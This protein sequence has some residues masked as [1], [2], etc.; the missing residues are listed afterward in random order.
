LNIPQ[1][2]QGN[3]SF[4]LDTGSDLNMIKL[5]QLLDEV[6]V[7][8]TQ[9]Y[10]LKGINEYLVY[11]IGLVTL[12]ILFGEQRIPTQFQVVRDDFPVPNA[13]IIGKPFLVNNSLTI[14]YQTSKV[15][16]SNPEII[17]LAARTETL[18]PII[19]NKPEGT[20]LLVHSQ[21]TSNEA[22]QLGNALNNVIQGQ[23][24]VVAINSTE[25]PINFII[26]KLEELSFEKFEEVNIYSVQ[27]KSETLN[28]GNRI[29]ILNKVLETEH[30]NQ[31]ERESLIHICEQYSDIFHLEGDK[32]TCTDTV[33]HEINTDTSIQPINERPYRLPFKH[34]QEID[35]QITKLEED[36]IVTPSKSPWNAPLLVVPKKPDQDG[37]IKYRVCVDFRKLNNISTGDAY[38]L[39]NINDILDQLGKS[40]YYTTLDLAQGY[41]QIQ[42][43]PEHREKTAFSTDK[44]HFEFLRVPFGLKGAPATFQRMMNSVLTGLTGLK[45]FVYL[46]DII[47]YAHNIQ[48]HAEK[49]QAV[50]NRLR[51][52]NLKLQ[53]SKCAFMRKEVNY[54]GHIITEKG[55]KPDPKKTKC[56]LN[57]PIPVN[58]KDVKSFLG[59]S[60]YYRRFIPNYGCIAK[61]LTTLL[62]K[63]T[64]FQWSDLCQKAFDELK[65]ILT[66]EPLLQYP[67]FN[68]PFNLTCDASNYAIGCVLS[69]GT[70]G[71]DPPIAYASRTLNRAEQNYSTT[72][73]EL[74]A[75][76]WGVKQ[77]RPYLL[78]QK[79]NII[80]DHRALSWLF[81]IKDPG[82]RLTRWRLKLEEYEYEIHYKPGSKNTNADALSR[83]NDV[84]TIQTRS[85][86]I[87]PLESIKSFDE[88]MADQINKHC[89]NTDVKEVTGNIFDAPENFNLA[90]CVSADLKLNKGLALEFR[91]KYGHIRELKL[92]NPSKT[93]IL[94]LQV[95]SRYILNLVTKEKF[96]QKPTYE[97]IYKTLI[98]LKQFCR[99]HKL[100][101]IALPRIAC[102]LDQLE[103]PTVLNM[104]RYIYQNSGI[105]IQV[106]ANQD[107][108]I[109]DKQ[110]IIKEHHSSILGGHRGVR[111]T[112]KRIQRQYN[113]KT[114]KQDVTEYI[115]KCVSCQSNKTS[116]R[117][118]KQ[119]M[120]I[121]T[122]ATEPFEKIFIDVVGPLPR[123]NNDNAYILTMQC[124]LTKFSIAVPMVNH[125]ANTVAYHFVTSFVCLHGIP[126]T[127]VSDQGTEFL[128]R[129]LIE[130]CKLLKIKKCNTSPYHPQANGAL[131]RSHR[132]L[133][134]YLRH[135][136][137]ADQ[138]NWDTYIPYAMFVYNSS[139]HQATGKQPYELLYGKTLQ[140]PTSCTKAPEPRYNYDDYQAELRQKLQESHQMARDRLIQKKIRTKNIYDRTA[141]PIVVHVGDKVLIQD[142]ARKGKLSAKWLGPYEVLEVNSQEN[143]T[144]RKGNRK[145]KIH[146]NLL[147]L[148][149]D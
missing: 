115:S 66:K 79:F 27:N 104:I 121:S 32:L 103:W 132:T 45:A 57:F 140:V 110:Q 123:T 107:R 16:Q 131:E 139:E 116:N 26:P 71:K 1:C 12:D 125:E 83:I 74:C 120:V 30:L 51:Q 5:S 44:G 2:S 6:L 72:E 62:K 70:I 18:V 58:T 106:Y 114:L 35:K 75:I 89:P 46:D 91:R 119:P 76:V 20:T 129:I 13:G 41:H 97:D 86:R 82:S 80:T 15:F 93:K 24:I 142:K 61:P 141:N 87:E 92:Q 38:P 4:L 117:N 23:V 63:D 112:I 102:G 50:F 52:F 88:Y 28:K 25:S 124:D 101:N 53:P 96:W 9:I 118:T 10:Q 7:D 55:V 17:Q 69:Q 95:G 34:K 94:Y 36:N 130:T 134:E 81:N 21:S 144:I 22:V 37:V 148:F 64:K 113:W 3:A 108:D 49:L 145:T 85:K 136:V 133:G 14:D 135:Y 73:K 47:I 149:H 42:M 143:V 99:E 19:T 77:F 54:L 100:Q 60:G 43:H 33:Y 105:Q 39:P 31:E 56:V 126:N 147:K 68:Q 59:L 84:K 98:N 122:T 128:S 8:E 40:R 11:T 146:T 111:Q 67:D 109:I 78:G 137:D 65:N 48:D 127:L 29:S 138:R 90:H